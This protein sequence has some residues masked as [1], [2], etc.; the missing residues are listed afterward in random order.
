[1]S[2]QITLQAP[3]QSVDWGLPLFLTKENK[4]LAGFLTAVVA[5]VLYLSSNHFHIFEPQLLPMSATDRMVPF[6]PETVWIYLSEYFFFIAVFVLCK[7]MA[8][9]NKYLYSFIALQTVSVFI[10]W[11][12][13]TT[14]PRELFPLNAAEMDSLTYRAFSHLRVADS[15]ANCCPS[16][17]VSSVYLSAF[18]YLDDQ[19][20]KF[21]FFFIWGTLIALSTLTTKQHYLVDVAC[22]FTMAV[23]FYWIFHRYIPYRPRLGAQA[24][25]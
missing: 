11:I 12:W 15:P 19:K 13:P 3:S 6:V 25:R 24:N 21:P 9:A 1:M 7:D 17:H 20:K 23:L 4:Y 16:L 8:N 2:D 14:Y 22:G 10:F 5:T 18:I